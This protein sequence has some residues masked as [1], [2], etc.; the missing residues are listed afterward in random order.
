MSRI[1]KE[2]WDNAP[3]KIIERKGKTRLEAKTNREDC[4]S[5]NV[6]LTPY[7]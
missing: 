4:T 2:T 7:G 5:L 6:I 1:P 3:S